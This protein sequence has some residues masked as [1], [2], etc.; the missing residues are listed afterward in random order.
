MKT[1]LI[2]VDIQNEFI[3]GKLPIPNSDSIIDKVNK[4]INKF[5]LV[6]YS[7]NISQ[8]NKNVNDFDNLKISDVD[9][10]CIEETSGSEIPNELNINENIFIRNYNDGFSALV[11]KKGDK[12]MLDFLKE[13]EI[14]HV[15]ISGMPADYSVKYTFLDSLKNFKTYIIIDMIKTINNMDNFINYCLNKKISLVISNNINTHL[16]G[17]KYTTNKKRNRPIKKTIISQDW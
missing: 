7:K 9:K 12:T 1:A 11:S 16:K 14:T 13:N 15:F 6:C 2:V 4:I 3:N 10:Y 17:F 5:D 8:K